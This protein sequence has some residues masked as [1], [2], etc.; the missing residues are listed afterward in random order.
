MFNFAER[1]MDI[2]ENIDITDADIL[3]AME[4]IPGYLDITPHSIKEIYTFAYRQA[5]SRLLREVTA[6]EIMTKDV[7]VVSTETPLA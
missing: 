2:P 7:V 1:V 4:K 6:R 5:R 3:A